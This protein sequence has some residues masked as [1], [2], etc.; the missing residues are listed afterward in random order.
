MGTDILIGSFER[1]FSYKGMNASEYGEKNAT[2]E[3][4]KSSV[5]VAFSGALQVH[6]AFL[7]LQVQSSLL[8]CIAVGLVIYTV[9]TIARTLESKEDAANRKELNGSRKEIGLAVSVFTF[10]VG[11]YLL[12]KSGMLIIAFIPFVIGYLYS[13]SVKVGK[14][15]VRL[16]GIAGVKNLVIGLTWGI[17]I[18][19]LAGKS[20]GSMVPVVLVFIFFGVKHFL[21]ST[22]SDF[23]DIKG[24]TLAGIETL[25]I[26]LGERNTCNLLTGMHLLSHLILGIAQIHGV[27]AFEPLIILTSFVLGL[28]FIQS[29]SRDVNEELPLQK[30]ART[31][32]MDGESALIL[33]LR[34]ISKALLI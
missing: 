1:F 5:R 9:Y 23:K 20:C 31:V 13:K 7:L 16:K 33:G 27:L 4:L 14:F 34:T 29:H 10:L 17:S 19:G 11:S 30:L 25:P 21:N 32:L 6:I 24:D 3:L 22:I 15:A 12:A 2:F 26:S 8:A 18:A 28:I